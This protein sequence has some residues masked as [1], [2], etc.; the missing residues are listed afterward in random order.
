MNLFTNT[1]IFF[2]LYLVYINIDI[3]IIKLKLL[4]NINIFIVGKKKINF[5]F[6]LAIELLINSYF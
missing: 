1:F 5:F 2:M 3:I 6:K 4:K